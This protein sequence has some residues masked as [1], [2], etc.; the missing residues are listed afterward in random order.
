VLYR[1][2]RPDVELRFVSVG[3][4]DGYEVVREDGAPDTRGGVVLID[5]FEVPAGEDDAFL[6]GWEAPR[7]PSRRSRATSAPAC[8]ARPA[9]PSSASSTRPPGRAR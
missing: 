3:E 6:A 9:P 4:G 5:P 8:T 7:R 2:L 1:A